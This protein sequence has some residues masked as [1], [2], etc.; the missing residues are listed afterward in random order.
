MVVYHRRAVGGNGRGGRTKN[1]Q[2]QITDHLHM[3]RRQETESDGKREQP[4]LAA[5]TLAGRGK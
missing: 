2:P 1:L 5:A 4:C 3:Q